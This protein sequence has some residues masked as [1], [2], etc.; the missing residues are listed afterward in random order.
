MLRLKRLWVPL[1]AASS[2]SACGKPLTAEE[3]DNL[4][5]RYTKLLARSY[6]HDV[7]AQELLELQAEARAKA[8]RDPAFSRCVSEVSRGEYEC[9]MKANDADE[10]E[11]CLIL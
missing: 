8:S 5:D 9:A 6:G 3:C 7:N 11:K 10:L 1:L 2:L 4:L